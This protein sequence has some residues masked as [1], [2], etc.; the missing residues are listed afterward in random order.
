[1]EKYNEIW[2][3]KAKLLQEEKQKKERIK[4]EKQLQLLLLLKISVK[5]DKEQHAQPPPLLL[6]AAHLFHCG[7]FS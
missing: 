5:L 4:N 6:P 2:R 1:M 3:I 7:L